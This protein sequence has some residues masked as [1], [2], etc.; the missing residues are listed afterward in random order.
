MSG[1]KKNPG[2]VVP[3]EP[4]ACKAGSIYETNVASS[5]VAG[6]AIGD[7]AITIVNQGLT[8]TEAERLFG[9]LFEQNFPKLQAAAQM[10]AKRRVEEF[11]ATFTRVAAEKKVTEEHLQSLEEPDI[12]CSLNEAL[13]VAARR[14]NDMVRALLARLIVQRLQ[15]ERDD[16]K[17]LLL[18]EA[19]A[20]VR[21]LSV[22]QLQTV[23][24]C[25][26]VRETTLK[27]DP[28]TWFRFNEV[29]ERM[30]VPFL[31][32]R[33]SNADLERIEHLGCGVIDFQLEPLNRIWPRRYSRVFAD[34]V[35]PNN[36]GSFEGVLRR[37]SPVGALV[38]DTWDRL[39]LSLLRLTRLGVVVAAASCEHLFEEKVPLDNWLR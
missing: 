17:D 25:H 8:F 12:Q 35:L 14:D 26:L 10:E 11:A 32:V 37:E 2:E 36:P 18:S 5:H 24:L 9:L 19:V 38:A 20:A 3:L 22:G 31:K 21:K 1:D 16:A 15:S 4:A 34:D 39:R 27:I 7:R 33:S 23:V 30:F 13:Q 6:I 28:P 29:L